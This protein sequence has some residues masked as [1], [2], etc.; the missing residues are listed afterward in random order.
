M[1]C[2]LVSPVH[3][4]RGIRAVRAKTV[5]KYATKGG[6]ANNERLL[7]GPTR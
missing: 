2:P 4:T 7:F 5:K 3:F 6:I 1:S